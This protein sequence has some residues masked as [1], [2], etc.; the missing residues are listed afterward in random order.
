LEE[1]EKMSMDF[2]AFGTRELIEYIESHTNIPN[3]DAYGDRELI[4]IAEKI[5]LRKYKKKK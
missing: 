4:G 5:K 1:K 3:L 2:Q